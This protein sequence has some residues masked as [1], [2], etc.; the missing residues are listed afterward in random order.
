M[1]GL[2]AAK[3]PLLIAIKLSK[4]PPSQVIICLG[5][6]HLVLLCVDDE[7]DEH[8][9]V[10][11]VAAQVVSVLS[12]RDAVEYN[13]V[14]CVAHC[15]YDVAQPDSNVYVLLQIVIINQTD[16]YDRV[17]SSSHHLIHSHNSHLM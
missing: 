1:V 4:T 12:S 3:R 11:L 9:Q 7:E 6:S 10:L 8:D 5:L 2:L 13:Q 17:A 14:L 15:V 16:S